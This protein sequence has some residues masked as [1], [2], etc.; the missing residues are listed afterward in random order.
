MRAAVG[1]GFDGVFA[2]EAA[3]EPAF[4]ALPLAAVARLLGGGRGNRLLCLLLLLGCA[5]CCAAEQ[6]I[7][8][9]GTFES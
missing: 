1:F 8:H 6:A 4:A 2:D 7:Q 5:T 9:A 3:R